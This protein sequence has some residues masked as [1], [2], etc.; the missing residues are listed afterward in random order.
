MVGVLF[1]L[2][3]ILGLG[4]SLLNT[5]N[6]IVQERTQELGMLRAIGQ[7]K[8]SV[9]FTLVL[10]AV[11]MMFIG[12]VIGILIGYILIQIASQI[13]IPI[14]TGLESMGI[15]PVIYPILRPELLMMVLVILVVLTLLISIIPSSKVLRLKIA[16]ALN[17]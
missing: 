16:D 9:F 14:A 10:E 2:I 11:V 13:G 7:G 17:S 12:A 4:F 6:M 5:M 1:T 15:R 3:I 8:W